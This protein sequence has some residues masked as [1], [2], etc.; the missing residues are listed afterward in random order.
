[1]KT[2]LLLLLLLHLQVSLLI[3]LTGELRSIWTI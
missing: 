2:V 1:M 3:M